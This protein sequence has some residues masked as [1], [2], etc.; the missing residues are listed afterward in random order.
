[1]SVPANGDVHA[2]GE[3]GTDPRANPGH[4]DFR[5]RGGSSPVAARAVGPCNRPRQK[6]DVAAMVRMVFI[7][8]VCT[9]THRVGSLELRPADTRASA[10]QIFAAIS[11]LRLVRASKDLQ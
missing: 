5:L 1:M 3:P 8:Q 10:Q 11:S 2:V 4:G 7:F 9:C 6:F